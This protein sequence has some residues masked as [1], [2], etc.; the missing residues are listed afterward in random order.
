MEQEENNTRRKFLRVGMLS[1]ATAGVAAAGLGFKKLSADEKV[2]ELTGKNIVMLS[3]EGELMPVDSSHKKKINRQNLMEF[4][5]RN[6][7][8]N[9]QR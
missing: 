5:V 4:L 1:A 7:C 8:V 6:L 9:C 3:P 2:H